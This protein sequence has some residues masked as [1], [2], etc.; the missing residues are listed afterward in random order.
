[1]CPLPRAVSTILARSDHSS[2]LGVCLAPRASKRSL[3][4]I[5]PDGRPLPCT[6]PQFPPGV[7]SAG[8][9]QRSM[10]THAGAVGG[11][12][13]PVAQDDTRDASTSAAIK[14]PTVVLMGGSS[15]TPMSS[16]DFSP[17]GGLTRLGMQSSSHFAPH[18]PRFASRASHCRLNNSS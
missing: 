18:S 8:F 4:A 14:K 1:M 10:K 6:A 7:V 16:T 15:P 2:L 5:A 17:D 3:W 12:G 13:Q 11:G 9:R